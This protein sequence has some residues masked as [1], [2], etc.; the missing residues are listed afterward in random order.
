MERQCYQD[1]K[2]W[3][4]SGIRLYN[5]SYC[6]RALG[7]HVCLRLIFTCFRFVLAASYWSLAAGSWPLATDCWLLAPGCFSIISFN[8]VLN[9]I[10]I[11][12]AF[13]ILSIAYWF[14]LWNFCRVMSTPLELSFEM[15]RL[16]GSATYF[17]F[18]L[19]GC[20]I[21][22]GG[23]SGGLAA[24]IYESSFRG[25]T[26]MVWRELVYF[27][28]LC[29]SVWWARAALFSWHTK[30]AISYFIADDT[31]DARQRGFSK[32]PALSI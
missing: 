12:L 11:Y 4:G 13:N 10:L 1:W 23:S 16:N 18:Q 29:L 15:K 30:P 22:F 31:G 27:W 3:F 6:Y 28:G 21:A 25:Y 9:S 2:I 24:V 32:L 14:I 7:Y 20:F 26:A 19:S 5:V 8:L 17:Q